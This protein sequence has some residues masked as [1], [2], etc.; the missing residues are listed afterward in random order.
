MPFLAKYVMKKASQ[1][2]QDQMNQQPKRNASGEK[3]YDKG[4]IEI[5]KKP[6]SSSSNVSSAGD[7]E[8]IDFEEV[9][10]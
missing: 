10:D 2:M 7:D 9:K 3:I 4:D 1:K 5:R 6:D 8:Y